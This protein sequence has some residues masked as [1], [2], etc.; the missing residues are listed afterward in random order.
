MGPL[1]LCGSSPPGTSAAVKR[2]E[3]RRSPL[4]E[5]ETAFD[6]LALAL[7]R[8][9]TAGAGASVASTIRG[10]RV[11]I[12]ATDPRRCLPGVLKSLEFVE[13]GWV[14]GPCFLLAGATGE[15]PPLQALPIGRRSSRAHHQAIRRERETSSCMLP[16]R[17]E[18]HTQTGQRQGAA[19]RRV[20][21]GGCSSRHA[22]F[23]MRG[24][25]SD[26]ITSRRS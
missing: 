18:D 20:N 12:C 13:G 14:L 1:K 16:L 26:K 19:T 2:T 5:G 17:A 24:L 25:W 15:W 22:C 6:D 4:G 3:P 8:E 23:S 9:S 11:P 10:V 7:K 21:D